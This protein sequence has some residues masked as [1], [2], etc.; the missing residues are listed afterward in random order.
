VSLK[1]NPAKLRDIAR[2]LGE[3]PQ[4][5]RNRVAARAAEA[6]TDLAL[7]SFDAGQT[8]FGDAWAPGD[9][10]RDVDL[11][12]SGALRG[13]LRFVASGSRVRCAMGVK[14]ARYQVGKRRVLP[15]PGQTMPDSWR[16]A[17]AA[18]TAEECDAH[19]RKVA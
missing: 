1:G 3:M 12:K 10:G 15:A 17:C 18:I 11:Y 5:V 19:A 8:P 4:V 7:S 6:I 9:D 14:H 13:S 2:N 16:A